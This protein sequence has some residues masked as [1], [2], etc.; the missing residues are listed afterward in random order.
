MLLMSVLISAL[1][2][3]TSTFAHRMSFRQLTALA[4]LGFLEVRGLE[5]SR[6]L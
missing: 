5:H 2:Q 1:S 6:V 3:H 4:F